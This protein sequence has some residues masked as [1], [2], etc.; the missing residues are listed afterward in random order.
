MSSNIDILNEIKSI[1]ANRE[2]NGY[3]DL[4]IKEK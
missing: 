2:K 4:I 3:E 1:Q